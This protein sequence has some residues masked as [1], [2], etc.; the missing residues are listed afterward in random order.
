M[1]RIA[2]P[3]TLVRLQH[4]PPKY[5]YLVE[6]EYTAVLETVAARIESSILSVG[7][8]LRSPN[9]QGRRLSNGRRGFDS[10]TKYQAAFAG[11]VKGVLSPEARF[12]TWTRY[13]NMAVVA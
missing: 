9:D 10:R 13:Q 5:A 4:E 12:D 1:R 6:M 3:P 11:S 8:K 2:N 7:T